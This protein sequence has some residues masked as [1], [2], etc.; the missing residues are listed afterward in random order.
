MNKILSIIL[1]LSISILSYV[2]SDNS[3][4]NMTNNI[5][6][7]YEIIEDDNKSQVIKISDYN[8]AEIMSKMDI[9]I[10][11][12][13]EVSGRTIIEGYSSNLNDY[14]VINNRKVNMQMSISDDYILIGYPLIKN[15]F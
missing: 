3:L 5:G 12:L 11:S 8:F 15:S 14:I 7:E 13:K 10:V 9:E 2:Y 1:I 4:I 6:V